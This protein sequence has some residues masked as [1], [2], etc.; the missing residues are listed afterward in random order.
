MASPDG[1]Q[2]SA[3]WRKSEGAY[4]SCR[5]GIVLTSF[6]ASLCM[7][8]I[9]LYQTGII[10]R[11]WNPAWRRLDSS[12]VAAV[13][14]AYRPLG[15]P[16]PDSLLG[17]VSYAATAALAGLGGPERH[18]RQPWLVLLMTGK[19]LG[20]A[21]LGAVLFGVQWAW[22]RTFCLYCV[23]TSALSLVAM[24]LVVPETWAAGKR[25][26]AQREKRHVLP[27][28]AG[29]AS[30]VSMVPSAGHRMRPSGA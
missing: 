9:G 20:D 2:L 22:Y 11:L 13:G 16:I 17:L 10:R 14:P 25:I 24:A 19:V 12:R 30:G 15:L 18:R 1:R 27:R 23:T 5:R 6:G 29:Q 8:A 26:V 28:G 4:L 7:I 21:A 3:T